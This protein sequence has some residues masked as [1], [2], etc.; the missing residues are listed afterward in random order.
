MSP[1]FSSFGI[2]VLWKFRDGKDQGN[3]V[4]ER[5]KQLV[6]LLQ[7]EDRLRQEREKD[8]D[9]N[10]DKRLWVHSSIYTRLTFLYMNINKQ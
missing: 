7:D 3:N 2:L 4:C 8:W 1:N 9:F 10:M 6:A 5:A